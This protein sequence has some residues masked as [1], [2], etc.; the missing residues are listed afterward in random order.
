MSRR[1]PEPRRR[2]VVLAALAVALLGACGKKAPL[3]LPDERPAERAAAPRVLVREGRATLALT[4]PGRRIFPERQ[5][6]WVHARVMRREAGA[7]DFAEA[8]TIL[9]PK[10]FVF[11]APLDW[12]DER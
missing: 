6:P 3:R 1:R 2:I 10:G 11:E 4:V 7:A 12:D 8:G 9:E 5:E